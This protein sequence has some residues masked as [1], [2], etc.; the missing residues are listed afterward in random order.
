M[1]WCACI[2]WYRLS[3][4]HN[5]WLVDEVAQLHR[6]FI[7]EMFQEFKV[8]F[9]FVLHSQTLLFSIPIAVR[10]RHRPLF[11]FFLHA[12]LV[13]I[14]KPFPVA[15]DVALYVTL[16][17]MLLPVL[18]WSQPGI[19]LA[20][21]MQMAAIMGPATLYL[22]LQTGS[23]NSNFFYA[24]TLVWAGAQVLI[25]LLI[26]FAVQQHDIDVSGK[27]WAFMLPHRAEAMQVGK[28]RGE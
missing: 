21:I 9:K 28:S 6:Y 27:A 15:A 26:T 4:L 25:M 7:G 13:A 3:V 17:S 22:W 18:G 24:M 1:I 10:F 11:S 19:V 16:L 14:F 23:A 12:M 20:F 5:S 8:F 2:I